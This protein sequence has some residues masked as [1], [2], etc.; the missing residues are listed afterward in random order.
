MIHGPTSTQGVV[1]GRRG[2]YKGPRVRRIAFLQCGAASRRS[3]PARPRRRRGGSRRRAPRR[4]RCSASQCT[5]HQCRRG[6]NLV[7][8][9]LAENEGDHVLACVEQAKD[10]VRRPAPGRAARRSSGPTPTAGR[11]RRRRR[12]TSPKSRGTEPPVRPV[13]IFDDR[14]GALDFTAPPRRVV[15]LVP[16]D[17]LS[18]AAL[19]CAGALVGRTDYCELP[20]D[21]VASAPERRR[22]QEPAR[23]RRLRAR[24]RSGPR[25]PGGEHARRPRGHRPARLPRVRRV[26]PARRRRARAPGEARAHLRRRGGRGGARAP[27]AAATTPS[28]TPR[29]PAART[30][31]LRAF[32]PIWMK[33]LMTIHGDTFISDML[34]LAA[35]RTS[36]PTASAATRSRRI[37]ARRRP[38]PPEKVGERDVR[39][40]RVTMEEVV[41]RAPEL[42]LLPGRAASLQRGGRGRLPRAGHPGG[43]GG[44]GRPHG[45][46]R[47]CAG[48]GRG[49]SRGSGG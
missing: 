14:G 40:P 49:A 15:S 27:R 18:V 29:P 28:A 26:P 19:G 8:D 44:R 43:E 23:R 7:I 11:P 38:L 36:S 3:R 46:A 37:S 22:D 47:T 10:G 13:R 4:A 39:Y 30:K 9:R 25:Q 41:A 21:V 1:D 32:C 2:Y 16:S 33:P 45:A 42:V 17:T 34:D 5:T 35:P 24:A 12:R 31:P 20:E 6:C 48:T